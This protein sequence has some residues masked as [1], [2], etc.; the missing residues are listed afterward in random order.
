[1][2]YKTKPSQKN[3]VS[4]WSHAVRLTGQDSL[5]QWVR[6]TSHLGCACPWISTLPFKGNTLPQFRE[7]SSFQSTNAMTQLT[8][9]VPVLPQKSLMSSW[10][11]RSSSRSTS[12]TIWWTLV[13]VQT[14]FRPTCRTGTT[15]FSAKHR[16]RR[17][18]YT[19]R[20]LRWAQMRM[21]G[22][23]LVMRRRQLGFSSSATILRILTP[24]IITA[25]STVCFH[26]SG[27]NDQSS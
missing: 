27:L 21:F 14:L 4:L 20:T 3:R 5:R 23:G 26:F 1:M 12:S 7:L 11:N 15:L 13:T 25:L 2:E 19:W 18:S 6:S 9:P 16:V 24:I 8:H 22:G 10:V 17:E